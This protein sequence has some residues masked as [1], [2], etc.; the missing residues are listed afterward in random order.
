MDGFKPLGDTNKYGCWF[1]VIFFLVG[2]A[3]SI[4]FISKAIIWICNHIHI[5]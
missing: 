1:I 5:S 3:S 2:L 4:Y